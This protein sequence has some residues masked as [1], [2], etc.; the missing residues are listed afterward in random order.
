MR[1]D[2]VLWVH[3][4]ASV[5]EGVSDPN[6]YKIF[7]FAGEPK[8]LYVATGRATGDARFDFFD[9]GF[10]HLPL[11][12]AR[13]NA[14]APP[15]RP[16]SYEEMLDMARAL[17]AGFPHVRVD[18]YDIAGRPYFGEMT[19]YHMS[20]LSPFEPEEYD[21]LFGSWLELPKGGDAR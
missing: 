16:A 11:A 6:D 14:S 3:G 10:N 21:E 13:P 17:S 1:D 4:G 20:G 9:I 12:N 5:P 7:C 2:S 19:F 8:A 15:G 18:F